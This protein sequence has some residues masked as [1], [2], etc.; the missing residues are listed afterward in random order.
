MICQAAR[1]K[2]HWH[3]A[4][5]SPLNYILITNLS[6]VVEQIAPFDRITAML[7]IERLGKVERQPGSHHFISTHELT[8]LPI[9]AAHLPRER[10]L[11]RLNPLYEGSAT[12][13]EQALELGAGALMLPM[14]Q[15]RDD[16]Q[17][18]LELVAGRARMFLLAETPASI[19]RLETYTD[20]LPRDAVI[21]LGLNDLRLQ[22][23]VDHMFESFAGGFVTMAADK[24]RTLG[25]PFGIGGVGLNPK[26]AI[27]PDLILRA[28]GA[29]GS[30]WVILSRSFLNTARSEI[31]A[32]FEH[33][34]TLA[35]KA[36]KTERD[37]WPE[38]ATQMWRALGHRID[39]ASHRAL[40]TA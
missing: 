32:A 40:R 21:H 26:D 16:V 1:V 31:P 4:W 2:K 27:P 30:E 6:D 28:H 11:V 24:L 7:D 19:L 12:E 36:A 8:D 18:F 33:I 34:D 29:L 23:G 5:E 35:Q 37:D 10:I 15:G 22:L 38:I 9:L 17:R 20:L 3:S 14:Y 13:V 25:A 39:P